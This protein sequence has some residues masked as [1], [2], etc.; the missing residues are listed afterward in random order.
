MAYKG[1]WRHY[2]EGVE[3][4]LQKIAKEKLLMTIYRV[5]EIEN[6]RANMPVKTCIF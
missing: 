2:H 3:L 5:E 1:I 6:T 4:Y